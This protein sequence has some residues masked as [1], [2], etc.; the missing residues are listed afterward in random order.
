MEYKEIVFCDKAPPGAHSIRCLRYARKVLMVS[1][2]TFCGRPVQNTKLI[3][4]T[5]VNSHNQT[6]Q[7][8]ALG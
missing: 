6:L 7:F 4:E 3:I 8:K 2:G 5:F 1:L